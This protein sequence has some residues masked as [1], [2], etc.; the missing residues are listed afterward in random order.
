MKKEESK[1]AFNKIQNIMKAPMNW[2]KYTSINAPPQGLK[3]LCF[4]E[5]DLWVCRRMRYKGID[6]WVEIPYGG[7]K[8]AVL[9]DAPKYWM[10]LDLPEGYTGFMKMFVDEDLLTFD[11]VNERAPELLE[12]FIEMIIKRPDTFCGKIDD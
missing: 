2:I 9:T 5:G 3:I 6:Y 7:K 11:E 8:G 12:R 4:R 1:F 10:R